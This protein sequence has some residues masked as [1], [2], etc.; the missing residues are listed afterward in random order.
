MH[1]FAV[2][3]AVCLD[4]CRIAHAGGSRAGRGDSRPGICTRSY[5]CSGYRFGT[6]TRF[7]PGFS[8]GS[9]PLPVTVPC[10]VLIRLA[11]FPVRCCGSCLRFCAAFSR[12]LFRPF[13][14]PSGR[15]GVFARICRG[16]VVERHRLVAVAGVL[17]RVVYERGGKTLRDIFAARITDMRMVLRGP[18]LLYEVHHAV[19]AAH[20]VERIPESDSRR[21]C[22]LALRVDHAL[23]GGHRHEL[24]V[25]QRAAVADAH[26]EDA[27]T[28]EALLYIADDPREG[29][30]IGVVFEHVGRHDVQAVLQHDQVVA[31]H[32]SDLLVHEAVGFEQRHAAVAADRVVVHAHAARVL[33]HDPVAGESVGPVQRHADAV[34]RCVDD[35][36]L[37]VF[38]RFGRE[39]AAY[40]IVDH[41][42]EPRI[43]AVGKDESRGTR[44]VDVLAESDALQPGGGAFLRN[45]DEARDEKAVFDC[46]GNLRAVADVVD[47]PVRERVQYRAAELGQ[48]RSERHEAYAPAPA[49]V[50]QLF[51]Q[52]GGDD[53]SLD[54]RVA[55]H[56]DT[57]GP[58][59]CAA[60]QRPVETHHRIG[61][62]QFD[63]HDVLVRSG[64]LGEQDRCGGGRI[65]RDVPL[66]ELRFGQ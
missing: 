54:K 2:P 25:A 26:H 63:R 15:E 49:E 7:C 12:I 64:G 43:V 30:R 38:A 53:V 52:V 47:V 62:E 33:E 28:G 11:A 61:A 6:C 4:T 57:H 34:Y 55:E 40:R 65:G 58:S 46:G 32:L 22:R 29:L 13:V 56:G 31:E 16:A 41:D 3:Y 35:D 59:C 9:G 39:E 10:C 42:V 60:G 1:P 27:R 45:A 48:R 21:L 20:R 36:L 44:L 66:F 19:L 14:F 50:L 18:L 17:L 5:P 8:S 23:H 37:Y 51:A 24:S